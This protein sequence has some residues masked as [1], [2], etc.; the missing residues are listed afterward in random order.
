MGQEGLKPFLQHM[1]KAGTWLQILPA[2]H[3]DCFFD[4]QSGKARLASHKGEV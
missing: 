4:A 2:T 1:E 3:G